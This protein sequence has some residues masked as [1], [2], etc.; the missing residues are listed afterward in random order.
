MAKE[1]V[2]VVEIGSSKLSCVVAQRGVN[3]IFNIK[4]KASVEY[5]GFFEGEFIE[6]SLLEDALLTLFAQIQAVYKKEID[7]VY[8]GVP[9]EFSKVVSTSEQLSFK[10]RKVVRQRDLDVLTENVSKKI[11]VDGMEIL[12][13]NPIFYVLDD[14]RKTSEPL[15]LKAGKISAE[16]STVLAQKEFIQLFN[17]I[18]TRLGISQVVYLSEPLCE[19]MLVLEK[20]E[21][22]RTCIVID[23]G[24]RSTSVAFVKGEGLTNLASFSL[25]GSYITSDLSSA[26]GIDYSDARRLK[27]HIVLSLRG[28]DEDCYE[29]SLLGGKVIKVPMNYANDVVCY[30]LEII[31]KTINECIRVFAKE[32]VPYYPIYL[33]GAGVSKIKGGKDY[34]ARCI[35]RSISYGLPPVPAMDKPENASLLGILNVALDDRTEIFRENFWK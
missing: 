18:W 35:G 12:S 5:A 33:C 11:E 32:H 25:G 8:V 1:Y 21:R 34:L 22:E 30:R 2:T 6:K 9:A 29:L 19:A 15:K 16:F 31:A 4:A 26:C 3:G 27:K 13:V 17:K 20:E 10:F 14:S 7:K 28:N 24:A 23:V